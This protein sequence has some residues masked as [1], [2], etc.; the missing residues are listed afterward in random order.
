MSAIRH[1][2]GGGHGTPHDSRVALVHPP[3]EVR[4]SSISSCVSRMGPPAISGPLYRRLAVLAMLWGSE[5]YLRR[6]SR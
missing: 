5:G 2:F 4:A 6:R 1:P 3:R